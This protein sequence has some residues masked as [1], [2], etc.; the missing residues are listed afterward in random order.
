MLMVR[1]SGEGSTGI[2]GI[3][4]E[5]LKLRQNK[6]LKIYDIMCTQDTL[7]E[8]EMQIKPQ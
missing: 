8:L 4:L 1:E 5:T 3:I 7:R 2:F 6:L